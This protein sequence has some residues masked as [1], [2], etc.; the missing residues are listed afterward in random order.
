MALPRQLFWGANCA[1]NDIVRAHAGMLEHNAK[2]HA[3]LNLN[4]HELRKTARPAAA[5]RG[6][7]AGETRARER[8]LLLQQLS[9]L[10][11]TVRQVVHDC[12]C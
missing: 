4:S 1:L 7:L 8:S 5:D 10:A 11:K 3:S 2:A 12:A 9:N 6:D